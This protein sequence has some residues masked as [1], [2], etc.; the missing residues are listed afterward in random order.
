[1][2]DPI[3][4]HTRAQSA[5][6]VWSSF[7]F[8]TFVKHCYVNKYFQLIYNVFHTIWFWHSFVWKDMTGLLPEVARARLPAAEVSVSRAGQRM[9]S[10]SL[11]RSFDLEFLWVSGFAFRTSVMACTR[12]CVGPQSDHRMSM[13]FL[14]S[15]PREA[16]RIRKETRAREA[17]LFCGNE[18]SA[19]FSLACF[20]HNVQMQD[21]FWGQAADAQAVSAS[22]WFL[23]LNTYI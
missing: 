17:L 1:M 16:A 6:E 18:V 13:K 12:L 2:S 10:S 5:V 4:D 20:R 8:R 19:K 23:M 7:L 22:I 14:R 15:D 11:Q 21:K 9:S 3:P